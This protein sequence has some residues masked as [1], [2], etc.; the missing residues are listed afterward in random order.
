MAEHLSLP[1]VDVSLE[2]RF[3]SS[4]KLEE[5]VKQS[6]T[7]HNDT[8]HILLE[9]IEEGIVE[10]T[11]NNNNSDKN[12]NTSILKSDQTGNA[13]AS[14]LSPCYPSMDFKGSINYV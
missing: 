2:D 13:L 14:S 3:G 7:R 12:D 5:A 11:K 8:E 10:S 6:D 1:L 4:K 9:T